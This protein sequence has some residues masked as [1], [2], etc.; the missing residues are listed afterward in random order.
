MINSVHQKQSFVVVIVLTIVT[1]TFLLS[2][3]TAVA[4]TDG[5]WLTINNGSNVIVED[6]TNR[7]DWVAGEYETC[8]EI[9]YRIERDG[10]TIGT[11]SWSY[12]PPAASG[13]EFFDA[14]EDLLGAQYFFS[15]T[16][17]GEVIEEEF[18][19]EPSIDLSLTR[20]EVKID[21]F[22][23][24]LQTQEVTWEASD[25]TSCTALT[26]ESSMG[27]EETT[28]DPDPSV[29][30]KLTLDSSLYN[31]PAT[32]SVVLTCDSEDGKITEKESFEVVSPT[33]PQMNMRV[34]IDYNT[35]L[36]LS[37]SRMQ[38]VDSAATCESQGDSGCN[39]TDNQCSYTYQA[40]LGEDAARTG[41]IQI[42]TET[43]AEAFCEIDGEE[44]SGFDSSGIRSH[45][46]LQ[47][48]DFIWS[49]QSI[50]ATCWQVVNGE[51]V[52]HR[53]QT[54]DLTFLLYKDADGDVIDPF[55]VEP[56]VELIPGD[57]EIT[58]DPWTG[59][60][61]TFLELQ[62]E[63]ITSCDQVIQ[64][65]PDGVQTLHSGDFIN[66]TY[67]TA[68]TYTYSVTCTR[69]M[70]TGE[71]LTA[72]ATAQVVVLP[73]ELEDPAVDFTLVQSPTDVGES[74]SE[75]VVAWSS[76][77]TSRCD[78]EG[79]S[80]PDAGVSIG[81][82]AADNSTSGD[83]TLVYSNIG[84]TV[85][86][87]VTCSRPLVDGKTATDFV[88]FELPLE[89]IDGVELLES[90]PT[91]NLTIFN[92]GDQLIDT[93]QLDPITGNVQVQVDYRGGEA[94]HCV[95][96][97]EIR[98]DEERVAFT[99]APTSRTADRVERTL[100][101]TGIYRYELQCERRLVGF[102]E[103]IPSELVIAT[104]DVLAA[105]PPPPPTAS[106]D[107]TVHESS[108][109]T[110][111]YR[112][113][114]ESEYTSQCQFSGFRDDTN[115]PVSLPALG[116][117]FGPSG[118]EI[119]RFSNVGHTYTVTVTCGRPHVDDQE[120]SDSDT[121]T[122]PLSENHAAPQT[123]NVEVRASDGVTQ[124]NSIRRDPFFGEANVNVVYEASFNA[125]RCYVLDETRPDN[126]TSGFAS[127]P[128][129]TTEATV[130][131][132]LEQDGWYEYEVV[133]GRN[134]S[135]AGQ[136]FQSRSEPATT[137]VLVEEPLPIDPPTASI[138][139]TPV[140]P[141]EEPV[142]PSSEYRIEWSSTNAAYCVVSHEVLSG[143]EVSGLDTDFG[144][145]TSGERTLNLENNGEEIEFEV[146]CGRLGDIA[147]DKAST[148]LELPL[149]ILI[150]DP[151]DSETA[152]DGSEEGETVIT[153]IQCFNEDG[154]EEN[155]V[156]EV[157]WRDS[158][159]FCRRRLPN[160]TPADTLSLLDPS[161][162]TAE[163]SG[164]SSLLFSDVPFSIAVQNPQED[165]LDS[166]QDI[167]GTLHKFNGS[168]LVGESTT[169]SLSIAYNQ[170]LSEAENWTILATNQLLEAGT[171]N[172]GP[173]QTRTIQ[174]VFNDLPPGTH[175]LR[176]NIDKRAGVRG[177]NDF[178]D[179]L[180]EFDVDFPAPTIELSVNPSIVRSGDEITVTWHIQDVT[181]P[182]QCRLV[183]PGV[184]DSDAPEGW[185]DV[186]DSDGAFT[187]M[188]SDSATI[189]PF[190][191]GY[192]NIRCRENVTQ[193]RE[194][195]G[196]EEQYIE[197]VPPFREI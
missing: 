77:H 78:F 57:E 23:G 53:T 41:E 131:R 42:R 138:D 158:D 169:Y 59:Q 22:T 143:G 168:L 24:E 63:N 156:P 119:V 116:A 5:S 155:I 16:C 139:V 197:V 71:D 99:T 51:E 35:N 126:T 37:S 188:A 113:Q 144:L 43:A 117:T 109:N 38:S 154:E 114:W 52:N 185:F 72:S 31:E 70:Q 74:Q 179:H 153:V 66:L 2:S 120:V 149:S 34:W 44:V 80:T 26:L 171:D 130:S 170:T 160:L 134:Y 58:L 122:L 62:T 105:D 148:T 49:D 83:A 129:K 141:E 145:A 68:G 151:D 73:S 40:G 142:P 65:A 1:F 86:I 88:E 84:A 177:V 79:Q 121:F 166:G 45:T 181:Y 97:D 60:A 173:N 196:E 67:T 162:W 106:L 100:N 46:L 108:D 81:S 7:L 180:I 102:D 125:T 36:G 110:T 54:V 82:L 132:D 33:L 92:M 101:Q 124:I 150:D 30:G 103:V 182:L 85:R 189:V 186:I 184:S 192:V 174:G 91:I 98:P 136:D 20:T 17:T 104:V 15:R 18:S 4:D 11:D 93:A 48:G 137:T 8:S 161:S 147:S 118:S 87:D 55:T 29:S 195:L 112:F 140:S 90:S 152:F 56:V 178:V 6:S 193:D 32:Y 190:S 123:V 146:E 25:V 89:L 12:N 69:E 21:P 39:C 76:E 50:T 94:T 115:E 9:R 159:G 194:V 165:P 164:T 183:G 47:T 10:E 175:T 167:G 14:P 133:C 107:I 19:I 172:W 157:T 28:I 27:P 111:D 127:T 187:S 3:N 61:S 96:R 64:T 13:T 163:L 191:A 95:L 176:I 75:V 135:I 128:T